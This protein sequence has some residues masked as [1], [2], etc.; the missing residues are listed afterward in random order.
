M[1]VNPKLDDCESFC[2][3]KLKLLKA[4]PFVF[5]WGQRIDLHRL[6]LGTGSKKVL[7]ICPACQKQCLKL[8]HMDGKVVCRICTGLKYASQSRSWEQRNLQRIRSL[9]DELGTQP[10]AATHLERPRYM[11]RRRFTD[12]VARLR[13]AE[14]ERIDHLWPPHAPDDDG[15]KRF[16]ESVSKPPR[17]EMRSETIVEYRVDRSRTDRPVRA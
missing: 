12:L 4:E 6:V 5:V 3:S 7:L 10:F 1:L 8:F 13:I 16:I 9:A 2:S 17:F 11:R 14:R 15:L